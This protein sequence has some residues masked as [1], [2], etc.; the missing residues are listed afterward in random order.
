MIHLVARRGRRGWTDRR[1]SV[2]RERR[3]RA[4]LATVT[5]HF[6]AILMGGGGRAKRAAA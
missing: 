2:A 4:G 5:V 6:V 3:R 1:G